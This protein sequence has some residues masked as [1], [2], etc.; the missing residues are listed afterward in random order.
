MSWIPIMMTDFS[1]SELVC[2]SAMMCLSV[3]PSFY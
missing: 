3:L 2:E 1:E